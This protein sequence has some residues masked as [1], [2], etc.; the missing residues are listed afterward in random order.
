MR[1]RCDGEQ[2][3]R[4]II[5]AACNVFSQKGF[6]DAT[7]EMI[8]REAEA[9]RAAINYHFGDKKSLYRAVWQHL[10]DAMDRD[11]PVSGTLPD[12]A[13]AKER[14]EAHIR[15]LL[16]RHFG[17]GSCWQLERLR[18][19]ERVNPTG[20][21]DDILQVHHE[22]NREQMLNVLEELLGRGALS[23]VIRFYETSVLALCR[24]PWATPS[25]F[26]VVPSERHRIDS[27]EI[28]VLARQV[29]HFLLAGI[30]LR[31]HLAEEEIQR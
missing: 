9:N 1:I 20:L 5:G 30:E 21:V 4:K 15:A 17:Q 26:A 14:L 10:L 25:P 19:L 18:D 13:T 3:R 29:T 22:H 23:S 16:N 11:H 24:G 7:H 6:S 8:C 28:D 12:R 31:V 27:E 2:T